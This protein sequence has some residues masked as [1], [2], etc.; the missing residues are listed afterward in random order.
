MAPLVGWDSHVV[1]ILFLENSVVDDVLEN[2]AFND[3]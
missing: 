1:L 3:M 2:T